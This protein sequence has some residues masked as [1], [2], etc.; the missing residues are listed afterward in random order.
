VHVYGQSLE[1]GADQSG[2]A[3]HRGLGRKLIAQAEAIAS[4]HGYV[5]LAVIS[6]VGTREYYAARGFVNG[7]LYMV[8]D[9]KAKK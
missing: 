7:A 8:K 5:N 1:V 6:A 2:A 3:Q 4:A 9:L